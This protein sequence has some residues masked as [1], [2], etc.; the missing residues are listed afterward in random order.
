MQPLAPDRNDHPMSG[1]RHDRVG[2]SGLRRF[3]A[4]LTMMLA[5]MIMTVAAISGAGSADAAPMRPAPAPPVV[6]SEPF[7]LL[8]GKTYSSVA[9]V[10]GMVPG[11]GP[12]RVSFGPRHSVGLNAGCNQHVGTARMAPRQLIVGRLAATRMACPGPR[13][14]ADRWLTTFTSVPLDWRLVGPVLSLS[15]PRHTVI[16]VE[17]QSRTR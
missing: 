6:P 7:A 11:G 4:R 17:Q 10:G 16:L 15:S 12:V 3:R 5:G 1:P 14:G 13:A 8:V 9:V 2:R